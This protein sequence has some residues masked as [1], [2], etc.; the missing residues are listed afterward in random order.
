MLGLVK[1]YLEKRIDILKLEV[2]EST[3]GKASKIGYA[4][5][6]ALFGIFFLLFLFVGIGFF[7]GYELQNF[8]YGFLIVA[9]FFLLSLLLLLL[10]KKSFIKYMREKLVDIILNGD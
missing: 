2:A 1:N 10:V 3:I 6:L 8:G 5:I 7:I 4:F 9:G